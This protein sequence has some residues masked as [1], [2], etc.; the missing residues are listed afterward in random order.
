M[1]A[2]TACSILRNLPE[3]SALVRLDRPWTLDRHIAVRTLEE[4]NH[5][6]RIAL[7]V[8]GVKKSKLPDP[9]IVPRPGDDKPTEPPP[10]RGW[11]AD[12]VSDGDVQVVRV[13]G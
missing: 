12:L 13:G 3:T 2:P 4:V 8:G 10:R 5:L 7:A 11:I 9:L 6:G 1:P